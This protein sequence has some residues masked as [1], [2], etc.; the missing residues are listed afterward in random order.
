MTTYTNHLLGALA[1]PRGLVWADEFDWSP[2]ESSFEYALNGALVLDA[3]Q[4]QSG[5][6]VTLLAEE[7]SGWMRRDV[8][9]A[10]QELASVPGAVYLLRLADGRTFDV[11][12]APGQSIKAYPIGRPELPLDSHPYVV[13]LALLTA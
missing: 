8:L 13:E 3:A 9:L 5:R 2:V 6:P 7:D 4:R 1:L 10:L 12:F 11:V